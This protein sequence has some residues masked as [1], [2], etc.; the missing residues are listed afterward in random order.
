MKEYIREQV[1]VLKD[2]LVWDKMN[3]DEKKDLKSRETEISVD[4]AM[5]AYIRKYL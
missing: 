3:K 1:R 5:R 4:N 2:L